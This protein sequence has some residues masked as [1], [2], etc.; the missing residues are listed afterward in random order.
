MLRSA[1]PASALYI[2]CKVMSIHCSSTPFPDNFTNQ[3]NF[4]V[5]PS[6]LS[7]ALSVALL[8]RRPVAHLKGRALEGVRGL[9]GAEAGVNKSNFVEGEHCEK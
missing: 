1:P 9:E 7:K 2:Q 4:H 8:W 6:W 3:Y 5:R